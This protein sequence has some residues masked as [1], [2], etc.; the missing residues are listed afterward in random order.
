MGSESVNVLSENSSSD[1]E[2]IDVE[3]CLNQRNK[4]ETLK[5]RVAFCHEKTLAIVHNIT[6]NLKIAHRR[7]LIP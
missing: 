5:I 4:F 7:H 3:P 2:D 6:S 1:A